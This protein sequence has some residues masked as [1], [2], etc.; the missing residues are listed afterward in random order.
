MRMEGCGLAET[1]PLPPL[2][3]VPGNLFTIYDIA[4]RVEVSEFE[5]GSDEVPPMVIEASGDVLLGGPGFLC[6]LRGPS[7][8]KRAL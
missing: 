2:S 3:L 5:P 8:P 6:T 4:A 1:Q 7:T